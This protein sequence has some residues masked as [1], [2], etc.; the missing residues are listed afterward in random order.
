MKRKALQGL[1]GLLP[2]MALAAALSGCGSGTVQGQGFLFD[3]FYSVSVSGPGS[4]GTMEN[5]IGT[6]EELSGA[7][8]L[9]YGTNAADLP[10]NPVYSDC[11]DKTLA[12]GERYGDGINPYCGALTGL[13]GISTDSPRIPSDEEIAQAL[14][15]IFPDAEGMRYDFGAA[16]KGYACDRAYDILE[17]T[18]A[19]YAVVS[20]SSTTLLYGQKPEGEK[21]RVGISDPFAGEG[22]LGTVTTGAAFVSTSGGYERYFEVD[23]KKYSHIMD[24]RTGRPTETDLI[25]VTVIV[26]A[27]TPDGGLMSDY[28]ATLI[29]M[30]G[31][32]NLD[33]WLGS[34]SIQVIAVDESGGVRSSCGGFE[35]G[36]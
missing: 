25:S 12:L 8:E 18:D 27:G 16:A 13:W 20:L 9:C 21:F 10:D 30:D 14:E 4:Q 19:D 36:V 11:L 15:K 6:L 7:F 17:S 5:I 32:E 31:T 26:P 23:G 2:A 24:T 22:Y 34:E 1:R 29:C 28:L 33:K 35:Y 3:T